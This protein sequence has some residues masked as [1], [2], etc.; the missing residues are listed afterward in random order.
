M[1]T[2]DAFGLANYS[3]TYPVVS[4]VGSIAN[5]VFSSVVGFMY[6]FSGGYTSTLILF[7]GGTVVMALSILFVYTHRA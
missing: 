3:K 7:A 4:L 1:I 2:R 6:D 5:A